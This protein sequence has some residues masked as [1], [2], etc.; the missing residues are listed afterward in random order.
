MIGSSES[1]FM[2]AARHQSQHCAGSAGRY[3]RHR[4]PGAQRGLERKGQRLG[5]AAASISASLPVSEVT[6]KCGFALPSVHSVLPGMICNERGATSQVASIGNAPDIFASVFTG[7]CGSPAI[8]SPAPRPTCPH[9]AIAIV[10]RPPRPTRASGKP[11]SRNQA[12]RLSGSLA[13]L[14]FR[15]IRPDAISLRDGTLN[16]QILAAG[17]L[18]PNSLDGCSQIR[19]SG[20]RP[21]RP[22]P[23]IASPGADARSQ[24]LST[25]LGGGRGDRRRACR[26][27]KP[28]RDQCGTVVHPPSGSPD[29]LSLMSLVGLSVLSPHTRSVH[30]TL[31]WRAWHKRAS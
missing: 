1:L 20:L 22:A 8:P 19:P 3:G 18:P 28:E 11:S 30:G 10:A 23:A 15:M 14:A 31:L 21:P 24:T 12:I 29:R 6:T 9:T 2:D 25:P 13:I 4:P 7:T 26:G 5:L 17:P 27:S 16:R